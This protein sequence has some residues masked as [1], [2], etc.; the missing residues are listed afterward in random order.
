MVE[1]RFETKFLKK[2]YSSRTLIDWPLRLWMV[3]CEALFLYNN[4]K[5]L[6]IVCIRESK[7][8]FFAQ[9]F[10]TLFFS[11]SDN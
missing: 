11:K 1:K 4:R 9:S 7:R 3:H 5:H 6:V 8:F 2:V 10:F